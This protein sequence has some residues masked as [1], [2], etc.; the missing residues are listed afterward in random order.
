MTAALATTTVEDET[1]EFYAPPLCARPARR[2][3]DDA[4]AITVAEEVAAKL[5]GGAAAKLLVTRVID[6]DGIDEKLSRGGRH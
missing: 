3:R 5:A 4:E 2:I 1:S 6:N